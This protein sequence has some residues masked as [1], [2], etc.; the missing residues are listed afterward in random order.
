MYGDEEGMVDLSEDILL[1][2]NSSNL[3]LL[4]DVFLL[5]RL[6]GVELT[7]GFLANKEHLSVG[8]FS[9]HWQGEVVVEWMISLHQLRFNLQYR[10]QYQFI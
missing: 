5:H 10:Q 6:K 4:L 8:A 9:Y 1:G 7:S 2:H 3:I